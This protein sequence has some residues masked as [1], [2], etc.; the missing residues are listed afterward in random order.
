MAC[1]ECS[2]QCCGLGRPRRRRR[3]RPARAKVL[4][5]PNWIAWAPPPHS[6]RWGRRKSRSREPRCVSFCAAWTDPSWVLAKSW[7]P[8]LAGSALRWPRSSLPPGW[9]PGPRSHCPILRQPAPQRRA[10]T[11]QRLRDRKTH[12]FA[13]TRLEAPTLQLARSL[14]RWSLG[15][16]AGRRPHSR[17][18][19][20]QRRRGPPRRRHL[21]LLRRPRLPLHSRPRHRHHHHQ[22]HRPRPFR[23]P[24]PNPRPRSR[25]RDWPS[26]LTTEMRGHSAPVCSPRID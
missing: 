3:S 5:R 13:C 12:A 18:R 7:R 9:V 25:S 1:W 8:R 2:Q 16:R 11:L 15:R 14:R 20:R 10:R 19:L 21:L 24:D 22:P 17:A 26:Q 4:W 23:P 6:R